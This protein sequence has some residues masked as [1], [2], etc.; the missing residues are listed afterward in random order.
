MCCLVVGSCK[1][2]SELVGP[3]LIFMLRKLKSHDF[4]QW[5]VIYVEMPCARTMKDYGYLGRV[6]E[7][8]RVATVWGGM[9]ADLHDRPW[10]CGKTAGFDRRE[11]WTVSLI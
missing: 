2:G 7:V 8:E 6:E 9:S 11:S 3:C 10:R 4:M 1:S 5:P